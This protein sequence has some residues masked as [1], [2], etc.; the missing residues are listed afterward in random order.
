MKRTTKAVI[1]AV[2]CGLAGCDAQDTN[3]SLAHR[4]E[5]PPESA[6]V[7]LVSMAGWIQTAETMGRI[8]RAMVRQISA[9]LSNHRITVKR[10][11]LGLL[12]EGDSELFLALEYEAWKQKKKT[13]AG[14]HNQFVAVG[15]SSGATAIYSLLRNGTFQNGP[16]AP[17][18][19]G[20]VDMSLPLGPHDLTGKTPRDGARQTIIVHYHIPGTD[21]IK[22]IRNIRVGTDHFSVVNS[23]TVTQGLAAAAT[24]A[25]LQNSIQKMDADN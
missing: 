10:R 13:T 22:G 17:A 21:R 25:C 23:R 9:N 20:L 15:H 2:I 3:Q 16:N 18:F 8:E 6:E 12:P 5:A 19:L 4:R 7:I 24:N 14:Q 11:L 1:F